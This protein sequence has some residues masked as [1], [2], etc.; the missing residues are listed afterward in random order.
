MKIANKILIALLIVTLLLSGLVLA[1]FVNPSL[2]PGIADFLYGKNNEE[3]A[4]EDAQDD[5]DMTPVTLMEYETEPEEVPGADVMQEN[6]ENSTGVP[7][8]LTSAEDMEEPVVDMEAY[9]PVVFDTTPADDYPFINNPYIEHSEEEVAVP[10]ELAVKTGYLAPFQ[11]RQEINEQQAEQ[12]E[13]KIGPGETGDGL[14]FA[15]YLYPYYHMLDDKGK[16]LYR[17]VYANAAAAHDAFSPVEDCTNADV[18][19]V[20]EAVFNDH[21]ELFWLDTAYSVKCLGNSKV[22]QINLKFNETADNL[23]NSKNRFDNA[24]ERMIAD[25]KN[26]GS[27]Y[28]KEL[29]VHDKLCEEVSYDLNAPMNQ[30]AYSALVNG[31]TVCAGYAR[32]MQHLMQQ[33]GIPCYY[34]TGF[35]GENHAW[36]IIK[37]DRDYYNVD[38]TWDDADP[39]NYDYFNKTDMDYWDTHVRKGLSVNLPACLGT[40]FTIENTSEDNIP[41]GWIYYENLIEDRPG[42]V[43]DNPIDPN[44]NTPLL[45]VR[46]YGNITL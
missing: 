45:D 40:Q 36:N 3:Q 34:C 46:I 31:S 38:A 6:Q 32:A 27:N 8:I 21:P 19:K 39:T 9:A 25:V 41:N 12:I 2:A 15:P 10:A 16:H 7:D 11:Y 22:A 1:C 17:Q 43:Y 26:L 14:D 37:L 24:T 44:Y 35:A 33:L 18:A 20:M 29:Y 28:L 30:S 23:A 4:E 13:E 42:E 5:I